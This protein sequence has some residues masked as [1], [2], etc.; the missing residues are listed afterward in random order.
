MVEAEGPRRR[1]QVGIIRPRELDVQALLANQRVGEIDVV[2]D[3]ERVGRVDAQRLL[4][5]I[6]DE[7]LVIRMYC[8]GRFCLAMPT[9]AMASAYGR[10]LPSRIGNLEVVEL[11]IRI[12]DAHTVQRREQVLDR[13]NPHASAH[14]RC[15]ISDSRNR[16]DIGSKLEIVE[17]D[18]SKNDSLTGRSRKNSNG[19]VLAR[20]KSDAAEF[21]RV[22]DSLLAHQVR[23]Q[24]ATE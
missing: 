8:R 9:R 10:A 21:E 18:A 2:S 6:Q 11:D 19:C 5:F 20:M 15:R 16:S 1:D 24:L 22:G 3:A 17:I 23:K 4:A 14:Q 12:V 7:S 13:R